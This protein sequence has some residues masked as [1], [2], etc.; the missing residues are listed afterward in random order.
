M[1]GFADLNDKSRP[2]ALV[3]EN[4]RDGNRRMS[5]RYKRYEDY[6]VYHVWDHF[7][8]TLDKWVEQ[9]TADIEWQLQ[10]IAIE[11]ER[12]KNLEERAKEGA[13]P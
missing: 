5:M 2:L 11:N 9:P 1:H 12:R 3:A 8:I 13:K 6:Y 10:R 7:H 4:P